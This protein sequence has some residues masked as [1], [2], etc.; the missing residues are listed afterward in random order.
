MTRLDPYKA[1]IAIE[2]LNESRVWPKGFHGYFKRFRVTLKRIM[3]S[4]VVDNFMTFSVFANTIILAIDHYGIEESV[5]NL[6]TNFN[7]FFTIVFALEMF[8]KIFA[9]GL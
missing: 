2:N 4:S 5:T 9:I 7:L 1:R 8:L 6:L 3:R